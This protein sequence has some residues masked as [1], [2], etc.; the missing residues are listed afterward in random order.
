M[1]TIAII[2]NSDL[3]D[4]SSNFA[5]QYDQLIRHLKGKYTFFKYR[6]S[7]ALNDKRIP[8][9]NKKPVPSLRRNIFA[10]I[11]ALCYAD[12]LLIK[13]LSLVWLFP[14]IRV[15]FRKKII[16]QINFTDMT[17]KKRN[18]FTTTWFKLKEKAAFR[19][20]HRIVTNN[21][22]IKDYIGA[23]YDKSVE[24]IAQGTDHVER[25]EATYADHLYHPFLKYTYAVSFFNESTSDASEMVLNAFKDVKNKYL[26][27][28][29]SWDK[30]AMGLRI[31]NKYAGY[32]NI[33]ML[34]YIHD[35]RQLDLIRSN[36]SFFI[37]TSGSGIDA[38]SMLEAMSLG[39]PVLAYESMDNKLLT[40][41]KASYYRNADDI[42][43]YL[44]TFSMER[45][46]KNALAMYEISSR[47]YKWDYISM[48]YDAVLCNV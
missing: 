21:E 36:A 14:F 32:A 34:P 35:K 7:G 45:M 1:K 11:H 10:I 37:H 9:R 2:E 28:I 12:V 25:V 33:F 5:Q 46:R 24:L 48:K 42:D 29:G 13:G 3:E 44:N 16:L 23:N 19:Y 17:S 30:T 8:V 6:T 40:E 41:A 31:K 43:H 22:Q 27:M 18:L 39:I 15:I 26:V 38:M 4:S 20:S 47:I